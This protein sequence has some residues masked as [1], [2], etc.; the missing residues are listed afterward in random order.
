MRRKTQLCFLLILTSI[1]SFSLYG[2]DQNNNVLPYKKKLKEKILK[3]EIFSEAKVKSLVLVQDQKTEEIQELRFSIAGF[4]QK[5]C[6]YALK[7]LSL[8]ESYS[9]FLDFVKSSEYSEEKQEINFLLSHTLLPYDMRLIF[10]LPR[11]TKE[12]VYPFSF[13]IG[14]LKDLKG[15]I[16]VEKVNNRCLFYSKA[17]WSGKDTKIPNTIFEIFSQTLAKLTM[18]RLFRIS[19]TLGH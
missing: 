17:D 14:L 5:S 2:A 11:I 8:Y 13:E 16:Y 10:K 9:K 7:K 6:E 3:G 15:T 12:G 19:N 18:E 4:H 1:V